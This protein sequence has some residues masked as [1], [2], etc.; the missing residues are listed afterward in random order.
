VWL[1]IEAHRAA[2]RALRMCKASDVDL[3]PDDESPFAHVPAQDAGPGP[4]QDGPFTYDKLIASTGRGTIRI[5]S[6]WRRVVGFV[7]IGV[8]GIVLVAAIVLR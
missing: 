7:A 8:V 4:L 2:D 6:G 3:D 5:G 1:A